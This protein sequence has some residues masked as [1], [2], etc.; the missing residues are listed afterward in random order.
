MG[1]ILIQPFQLSFNSSFN[2]GFH[3]S[4]VTSDSGPIHVREVD[5]RL[6]FGD[7]IEEHLTDLRP[8]K[9]RISPSPTCCGSP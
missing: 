8:V 7:L 9:G 5:E 3:G 6:A 1:E 2:V 4:R